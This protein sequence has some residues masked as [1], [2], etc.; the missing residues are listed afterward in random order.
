MRSSAPVVRNV[1]WAVSSANH[2]VATLC[3]IVGASASGFYQP[4]DEFGLD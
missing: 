2:A 4:V 3:R 1:T